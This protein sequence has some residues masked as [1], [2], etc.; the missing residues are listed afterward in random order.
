VEGLV[1]GIRRLIL[2]H[3]LTNKT[4]FRVHINNFSESSLDILVMFY[5]DV[6]DY[7]A[8]LREREAILWRTVEL[9]NEIGIEFK[10]FKGAVSP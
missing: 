9:V 7:G 4:N 8:E 6:Q 10:G 3:S 1:A 2:D 5:L